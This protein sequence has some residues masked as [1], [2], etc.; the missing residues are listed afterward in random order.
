MRRDWEK[1]IK[2]LIKVNWVSIE[3]LWEILLIQEEKERES[4][5]E[6]NAITN[7]SEWEERK[8]EIEKPKNFWSCCTSCDDASLR[9]GFELF[10][11]QNSNDLTARPPC[12]EIETV[13]LRARVG[14]LE[15]RLNWL[16]RL[17]RHDGV[18]WARLAIQ[19]DGRWREMSCRN[20]FINA[21]NDLSSFHSL[22]FSV[23]SRW[24]REV[25]HSYKYSL[26]LM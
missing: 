3:M 2:M 17:T 5:R 4:T 18:G 16:D 10:T 21:G 8:P 13:V 19:D 7:L 25:Y 23:A 6:W 14:Q 26:E 20:F 15:N 24:T 12:V 11:S 1:I 22:D 9:V